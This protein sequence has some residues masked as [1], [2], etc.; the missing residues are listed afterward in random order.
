MAPSGE[1]TAGLQAL[2]EVSALHAGL[3]SGR[4]QGDSRHAPPCGFRQ[5]TGSAEAC[6][7]RQDLA[8]AGPVTVKALSD[9]IF[10]SVTI[11]SAC[12]SGTADAAKNH[13]KVSVATEFTSA[14]TFP[15]S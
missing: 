3:S 10:R 2:C 11:L 13:N 7:R 6:A 5:Q 14:W 15:H 9:V 4:A 1:A 8:S 12:T